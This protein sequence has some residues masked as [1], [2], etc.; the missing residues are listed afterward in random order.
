MRL[1]EINIDALKQVL[2]ALMPTEQAAFVEAAYAQV[3]AAEQRGYAEGLKAYDAGEM[4]GY[5]RGFRDAETFNEKEKAEQ[6]ANGYDF[7]YDT[8]VQNQAITAAVSIEE[9]A[10]E[11][12]EGCD[13]ILCRAIREEAATES[14]DDGGY[15][16]PTDIVR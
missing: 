3:D 16:F 12:L 8:A 7:S 4:A 1:V 2:N 6:F 13:C 11:P 9:P 15:Q 5:Q 14:E 10:P